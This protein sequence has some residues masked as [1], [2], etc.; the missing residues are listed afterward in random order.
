E[1]LPGRRNERGMARQQRREMRRLAQ[2]EAVRASD[3]KAAGVEMAGA[4]TESGATEIRARDGEVAEAFA[5][6]TGATANEQ[7]AMT[8]AAGAA[9]APARKSSWSAR[10]KSL[11][12]SETAMV[13]EMIREAA[14][15]RKTE[16]PDSGAL[17]FDGRRISPR[18]AASDSQLPSV[19]LFNE[20]QMR[21]EQA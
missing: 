16:A 11:E 2:V 14:V 4:Q 13:Q 10:G 21:R 8:A 1:R 17:P 15:K 20:G 19:N 5:S 18:T 3:I 6:F 9:T 12:A 7:R